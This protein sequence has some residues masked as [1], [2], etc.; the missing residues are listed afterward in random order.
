MDLFD[1]SLLI[2]SAVCFL[3]LL[4]MGL[5]IVSMNKRY[6]AWKDNLGH[7][8]ML[9]AVLNGLIYLAMVVVIVIGVV[10]GQ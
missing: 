6:A 2:T 8:F 3:S 9:L 5:C 10:S 1:A 4:A 7:M